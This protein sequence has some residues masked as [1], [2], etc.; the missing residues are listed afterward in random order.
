[1]AE[2]QR[3]IG[4]FEILLRIGR[5]GMATVYLAGVPLKEVASV[6]SR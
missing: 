6:V 4:R 3:T 5:G 1:M 2:T